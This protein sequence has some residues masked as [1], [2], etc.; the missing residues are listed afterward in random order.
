MTIPRPEYPRP[1]LVR[2]EWVN[3]NGVWAYEEDPNDEGLASHWYEHGLDT[4]REIVVPFPV[5]SEASGVHNLNPPDVVW[6]ERH[7]KVPDDWDSQIVLR[8]GAVDHW[9]RVFVNGLPPYRRGDDAGK[10]T[11]E[12]KGGYRL[13]RHRWESANHRR[14][15]TS[16]H[17][18]SH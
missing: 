6:Y 1:T 5:E 8:F 3:L 7:F 10:H 12:A 2:N 13:R 15:A 14:R 4:T 11:W 9:A 17:H 18:A 16:Q